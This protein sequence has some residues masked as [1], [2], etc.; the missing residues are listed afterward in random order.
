MPAHFRAFR[1][2]GKHSPG[3]FLVPQRLDVG[4]AIDELPL[5]SWGRSTGIR[6]SGLWTLM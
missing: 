1:N 5:T 4:M 2:A 6:F 3:V